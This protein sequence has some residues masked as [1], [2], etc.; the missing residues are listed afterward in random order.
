MGEL[1]E[2]YLIDAMIFKIFLKPYQKLQN[3][4]L[5]GDTKIIRSTT[6]Y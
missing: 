2:T 4:S 3:L 1:T 6:D 5:W